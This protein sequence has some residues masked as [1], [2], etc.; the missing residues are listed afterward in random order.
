MCVKYALTPWAA[1]GYSG[2]PAGM[3]FLSLLSWGK[4]TLAGGSVCTECIGI[5]QVERGKLNNGFVHLL[6]VP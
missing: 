2:S 5:G 1:S 6:H 3:G 4:F